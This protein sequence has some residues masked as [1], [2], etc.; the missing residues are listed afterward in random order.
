MSASAFLDQVAGDLGSE[1]LGHAEG[2]VQGRAR[3]GMDGTSG[4]GMGVLDGFSAVTGRGA[5]I[6]VEFDDADDWQWAIDTW[7]DLRPA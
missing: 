7:R 5:A 6:R 2:P 3:L 4:V 1:A